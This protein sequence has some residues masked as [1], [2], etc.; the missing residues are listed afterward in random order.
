VITNALQYAWNRG[1]DN[2]L[3]TAGD[4]LWDGI[5]V[6]EIPELPVIP[7]AGGAGIDIA[8]NYLCGAQALGV[9]W[10]QRM[11]STINTRDYGFMHGVGLQEIRGIG[12]LRFGTDPTVDTTKPVDN[13]IV[14]FQTA[15]TADA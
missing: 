15:A 14:T 1:S 6:K 5:I 12:K 4:I 13:G 11:K 7:G 8:N 2:P 9:A 10:A 3:F